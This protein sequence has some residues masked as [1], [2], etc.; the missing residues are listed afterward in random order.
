VYESSLGQTSSTTG[1]GGG[2][3]GGVVS[4]IWM[5]IG[6]LAINVTDGASAA[7]FI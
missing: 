4:I 2:G 5:D 7:T 6:L 3:G 1:G